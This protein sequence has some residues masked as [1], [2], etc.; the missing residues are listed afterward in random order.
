MKNTRCA[1]IGS[2]GYIG[3]HLTIYL[4]E[5]GIHAAC[6]DIHDQVIFDNYQTVDLT[7]IKQVESI[8][9]NVD[10]IFMMSGLTGTFNGFDNYRDYIE[11][12][13]IG[14]LNVL[15]VIRHS[16]FRPRIIFPSTRLVYKGVDR[17]LKENDAKEAKTIYALNKLACENLLGMY[18]NNFEIPYTIL[19]LCLPYGNL[20]SEEY[21]YGTVGFFV[22]MASQ[23]KYITLYGDGSLKRTFTHIEDLCYQ[24]VT[25]GLSPKAENGTFNIGGETLSLKVAANI[26]A[27][28]YSTD[29]SFIPWPEKDLRIESGHTYFDD[30]HIQS[31]LNGYQYKKLSDFFT[32]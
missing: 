25:C 32:K 22:K 11:I 1:I 20:H 23:G 6:Y 31:I 2:N 19:R 26:V 21:S 5:L 10:Y 29:L 9:F 4:R 14:L 27:Q 17:P 30:S 24:F 13:E 7:N 18:Q 12:N 3:R 8:N 28:K 15:D 16:S